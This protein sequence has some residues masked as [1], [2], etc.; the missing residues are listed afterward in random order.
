[1]A[2][3]GDTVRLGVEFRDFDGYLVDPSSITLKVFSVKKDLLFSVAITSADKVS[4]GIYEYDYVLPY[5]HTKLFYEW[6]AIVSSGPMVERGTIDVEFVGTGATQSSTVIYATTATDH[7]GLS[8]RNAL[9]QH[10]SESIGFNKIVPREDGNYAIQFTKAD[11]TTEVMRVDTFKSWLELSGIVDG[12]QEVNV[13]NTSTG[14]NAS[15]DL[16]VTGSDGDD[17]FH[18]LDIGING[19]G[20]ED[21]EFTITGAGGAYIY[22][23][24]AELAIGST[25]TLPI[26]F[27]IGGTLVTNEV[28][29][30][31]QDGK[32]GIGEAA[33]T[34]FLTNNGSEAKGYTIL[35]GNSTL[36]ETHHIV[37][38]TASTPCTIT[39]PP[40][41]TCPGR[42]Y[43]V[44]RTGTANVTIQADGL[45]TI[46]GESSIV[47]ATQ[48]HFK[49]LVSD[50][51][52]WNIIG[53]LTL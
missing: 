26:K 10:P 45:E 36:N 4:T 44:K 11:G 19:Q 24:Q 15:S 48:Y 30:I 35:N 12:Y 41:A 32:L 46:D 31:T 13:H 34:S 42:I 9:N 8:N 28:M 49:K 7:N 5:N 20:F 18:Y 51:Q 2:I 43:V 17:D 39:L 37:L 29:R 40:A 47:L 23:D 27:F 3:Q 1:M 33:P 25:G 38:I 21:E 6:A 52:N 22:A 16:V 14:A 53:G 50:S